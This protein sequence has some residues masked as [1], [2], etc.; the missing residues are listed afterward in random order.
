MSN[1]PRAELAHL[2]AALEEHL[3]AIIN[4]RGEH[5]AA[6]DNTYVAIANA[7]ERYEEALFDA[8][9]EVTPLEVFIED[10]DDDD[11]FDYDFD[12]EDDEDDDEVEYYLDEEQK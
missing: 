7:F 11:D 2:T 5:D 6:V 10:E 4:S 12:E 3:N 8:Y 9:E 1:N